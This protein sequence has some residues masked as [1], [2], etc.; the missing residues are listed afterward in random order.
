MGASIA[1]IISVVDNGNNNT[2]DVPSYKI[3]TS[4]AVLFAGDNNVLVIGEGANIVN[5][6][7]R[8]QGSNS[9][10]TI[11]AKCKLNGDYIVRDGCV[12]EIGYGTKFNN[13]AARLHCGESNTSILIGERCLFA[14]VRFRTSD[15]H[16]IVDKVSRKRLNP[17]ANIIIE[18]RVW[19]A[20]EVNVYKGVT[21][22]SGSIVGARAT[23]TR[24]LPGD[25]LCLGTP[26]KVVK[27]GVAWVEDPTK[28]LP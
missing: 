20:E 4:A 2:Y 26:A 25:S 8:F 21:V 23:V 16:S 19:I 6:R 12:I 10:I 17:A 1:K 3:K 9:R 15:Q 27:S 11:G 7:F 14:N 18:S 13:P 28:N 24:S 22:G 5:A